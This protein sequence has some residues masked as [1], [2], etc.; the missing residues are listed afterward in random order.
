LLVVQ[1]VNVFVHAQQGANDMSTNHNLAEDLLPELDPHAATLDLVRQFIEEMEIT[2]PE[3]IALTQSDV[4]MAG[5]YLYE[6]GS[7]RAGATSRW[8]AFMPWGFFRAIDHMSPHQRMGVGLRLMGFFSWLVFRDLVRPQRGLQILA[9]LRDA[10]PGSPILAN[11]YR[12]AERQILELQAAADAL[13][14]N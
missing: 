10:A 8:E 13:R 7:H 5:E 11:L 9:R 1:G 2:E 12:C 4:L 14:A 6:T 3:E